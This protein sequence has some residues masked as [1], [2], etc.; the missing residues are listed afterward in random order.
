MA[1][2]HSTVSPRALR[3]NGLHVACYSTCFG[4]AILDGWGQSVRCSR[5]GDS[6]GDP[7]GTCH[8]LT[9]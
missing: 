1:V 3:Q 5:A 6:E 2:E 4:P 7:C 9:V 8:C